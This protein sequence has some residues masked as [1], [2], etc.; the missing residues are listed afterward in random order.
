MYLCLQ[1]FNPLAP[2]PPSW[3]RRACKLA[4]DYLHV[5]ARRV[6]QRLT[7]EL[8]CMQ[9][10][11]TSLGDRLRMRQEPRAQCGVH[12]EKVVNASG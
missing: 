6:K 2:S 10:M 4:L 5:S 9:Q 11:L 7:S 3:S 12:E 8:W 1:H